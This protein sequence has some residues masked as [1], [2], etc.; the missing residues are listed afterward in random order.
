[1]AKRDANAAVCVAVSVALALTPAGGVCPVA[2]ADEA[3]GVQVAAAGAAGADAG[4]DEG[5]GDGVA[6]SGDVTSGDALAGGAAGESAGS[7]ADAAGAQAGEAADSDGNADDMGIGDAAGEPRDDAYADGV[8][9]AGQDAE[10]HALAATTLAAAENA[11]EVTAAAATRDESI[12]DLWSAQEGG[13]TRPLTISEGGTYRLTADMTATSRV[14]IDAADA[15]VVIDLGTS[16]L[17]FK[18]ILSASAITVTSAKSVRI[19]G[20]GRSYDQAQLVQTGSALTN[21][22]ES[23]QGDLTVEG[24]GMRMR[25]GDDSF[26]LADLGASAVYA[27]VGTATLT[28]CSIFIDQSNQTKTNVDNG[29]GLKNC[30]RGIYLGSRITQATVRDCTVRVSGSPAAELRED[31]A[32]SNTSCANAYGLYTLSKGQVDVLGCSF[33]VTSPRGYATAVQGKNLRIAGSD[34]AAQTRLVVSA[35]QAAVG[36]RSTAAGG[37][38]LDGALAVSYGEDSAGTCATLSSQVE[39]AFVFVA[40]FSCEAAGVLVGDIQGAANSDGAVIGHVADGVNASVRAAIAKMLA[41]AYGVE[42]PCEVVVDSSG[43]FAFKLDVSRAPAEVVAADGAT[44]ACASVADAVS[45]AADGSTVRLLAD[46]E[47]IAFATDEGAT[48]KLDLNGHAVRTLTVTGVGGLSVLSSAAGG[49]VRTSGLSGTAVTHAGQGR[50]SLSGIDIFASSSSVAVVGVDATAGGALEL[51][52]VNVSAASSYGSVYGVRAAGAVSVHAGSISASTASTDVPVHGLVSTS[53]AALSCVGCAV[54]VRGVSGTTGGIDAAGEVRVAGENGKQAEVSASASGSPARMW[55]IRVR[56][57]SAATVDGVAVSVSAADAVGAAGAG[58]AGD[59][60]GDGASAGSDGGGFAGADDGGSDTCVGG[61]GAAGPTGQAERWCLASGDSG[62]SAPVNWYVDGNCSLKTNGSASIGVQQMPVKIGERFTL[63][64]DQ[65]TIAAS[66]LTA[67]ECFICANDQ[68]AQSLAGRFVAADSCAYAGWTLTAQSGGKLAWAHEAVAKVVETGDAFASVSEA[69]GAAQDGQTVQLVADAQVRGSV[70]I[71]ANIALDL[72]GHSIDWQSSTAQLTATDG[73]CA[74]LAVAAGASL[75][76]RDSGREGG[77][78]S[79]SICVSNAL[80]TPPVNDI[81]AAYIASGGSLSVDGAVVS[82][83][84]EPGGSATAS[85]A[86]SGVKASG[87]V[88]LNGAASLAVSAAAADSGEGAGAVYGIDAA[89]GV[90]VSADAAVSVSNSAENPQR[91]DVTTSASGA[92]GRGRTL[93]EFS[94]DP[95]SDLYAE[96]Q[97][98]FYLQASVD[99]TAEDSDCPYG[100]NVYYAAPL[101]LSDG[102]LIWAYSDPVALEDVGK[103]DKIKA[104]HFLAQ[105]YYD[106]VSQSVGLRLSGAACTATIDGAVS[107]T[108]DHGEAT[109]VS[110]SDGATLLASSA[111]KLSATVSADAQPVR[112]LGDPIDLRAALGLDAASFLTAVYY[113]SGSSGTWVNWE[114]PTATCVDAAATAGS[115][116][117]S[118]ASQSASAPSGGI[119]TPSAPQSSRSQTVAVIFSNM[120]DESGAAVADETAEVDFGETLSQA[121]ATL[122]SPADFAVGGV[123]YRFVGWSVRTSQNRTFTYDPTRIAAALAIDGSLSGAAAG[124]VT[125]SAV[126]VPVC[127]GQ[128][129]ITFQIDDCIQAYGADAGSRPDYRAATAGAQFSSP[130]K[131]SEQDGVTYGFSGWVAEGAADGATIAGSLPQVAGDARYVAVFAQTKSGEQISFSHWGSVSGETTRTQT[132]TSVAYGSSV[133]DAADAAVAGY[134]RFAKEGVVYELA[135]WAPRRSD[136]AAAYATSADLPA[137]TG[138][139]TYYGIYTQSEQLIDVTFVVDGKAYASATSVPATSTIDSALLLY[140]KQSR[141]AD[142]DDERRFRGWALAENAESPLMGSVKTLAELV[143]VDEPIT[144]YAVFGDPA[145]DDDAT[146]ATDADGSGNHE[147]AGTLPTDSDDDDD[148]KQQVETGKRGQTLQMGTTSAAQ[149]ASSPAT[150]AARSAQRVSSDAAASSGARVVTG[151]PIIPVEEVARNASDQSQDQAADSA[152]DDSTANVV[153][154][155][156]FVGALAAAAAGLLF[157]FLRNRKLDDEDDF[158]EPGVGDANS[159]GDGG[160]GSANDGESLDF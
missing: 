41:N 5:V 82:A 17:T 130:G 33:D 32:W 106:A 102:T 154:F 79:L 104:T 88:A 3:A 94:P 15:D 13:T 99:S 71:Q 23:K 72:A 125:L 66:G 119:E 47:D 58:E 54:S 36:I 112:V 20:A 26:S 67:G 38:A 95:S 96:I 76:V 105:S 8:S 158:Y 93:M 60:A 22:I 89:G 146:D 159:S 156:A 131:I 160:V 91:G 62:T 101:E 153:G 9:N 74:P 121:G 110:V 56:S 42:A 141:P 6:A 139:A 44:I 157:A 90:A 132:T 111:A 116:S 46:A 115:V 137:A 127:A 59:G 55:G 149:G 29:G 48:Y 2:L 4:G 124:S 108:S 126:Y 138:D 134:T 43:K 142:K 52:G 21:L 7:A 118:G 16:T 123:T 135:G 120:R 14:E 31:E 61:K 85:V 39:D 68:Q 69:L 117:V 11:D 150:D 143:K 107:A 64:E 148:Q 152:A 12:N 70:A 51:D 10:G 113:P 40:G 19:V 65:A 136:I 84:Y 45:R 30:P 28:G 147:T 80:A 25:S 87:D 37:V 144:L 109:A 73:V 81:A 53:A 151:D 24:V 98:A 122:P 1:M 133:A 114:Y 57:A 77:A 145:A 92:G 129:L 75:T 18:D 83:A 100:A 97:Q 27:S 86:F 155:F 63:Q 103:P 50:L 78:G 35:G 34:S 49:C 128:S 140:G